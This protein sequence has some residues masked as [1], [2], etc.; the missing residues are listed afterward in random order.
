MKKDYFIDKNTRFIDNLFLTILYTATFV[1]NKI[2]R[3]EK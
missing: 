1:T 3:Y 2:Y